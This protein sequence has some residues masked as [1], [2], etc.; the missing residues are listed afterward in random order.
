MKS[1][2]E[3]SIPI[4]T[5]HIVNKQASVNHYRYLN[6]HKQPCN[7]ATRNTGCSLLHLLVKLKEMACPGRHGLSGSRNF[8]EP[9]T[10]AN[11]VSH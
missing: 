5:V 10:D 3:G 9:A 6:I 8:S 7:C 4:S 2:Q 11:D 1:F